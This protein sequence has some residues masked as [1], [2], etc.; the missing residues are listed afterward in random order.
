[1]S[2]QTT[3]AALATVVSVV[4]VLSVYRLGRRQKLSFRYTV[5]WLVLGGL[6][7][8][9]GIFSPLAEPLAEQLNLSP[10]A[11]LGVGGLLLLLVLCV[12]L[13]ISISGLQEQVRTLAEEA[14]YLRQELDETRS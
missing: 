2:P 13:S 7:I 11:L 12:Q 9:A 4:F 6:G 14:S 8:V 5:G 1:M 10:A 3:Q